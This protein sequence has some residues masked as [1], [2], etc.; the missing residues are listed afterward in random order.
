MIYLSPETI[1][2]IGRLALFLMD[3]QNQKETEKLS[4]SKRK[5]SGG[6]G[7]CGKYKGK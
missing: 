2:E 6:G 4:G 1:R 7:V 3:Q 5:R